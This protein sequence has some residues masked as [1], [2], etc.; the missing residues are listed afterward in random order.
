MLSRLNSLTAAGAN[1]VK[2]QLTQRSLAVASTS[3]VAHRSH[4]IVASKQNKNNSSNNN[5]NYNNSNNSRQSS[6]GSRAKYFAAAGV[7]AAGL[8]LLLSSDRNKAFAYSDAPSSNST[9]SKTESQKAQTSEEIIAEIKNRIEFVR[10]QLPGDFQALIDA[11]FAHILTP[12]GD[13]TKFAIFDYG[14]SVAS[15]I[16]HTLLSPTATG[17]QV[18]TLC[19]EALQN[20]FAAVCVNS[21]QA[22]RALHFLK[23]RQDPN[24][25]HQ[26]SVAAVVGFPLG[27]STTEVKFFEAFQMNKMGVHEL[28]MVINMGKLI[29]R[30]YL[31]VL[32][33]IAG[34]TNVVEKPICVKVILETGALNREQIIDGCILSVLAGATFVK[35]STGFGYGGATVE[36]VKLMKTVVGDNALVKASGGVKNYEDA[37]AMI[38]AGAARIGASKGISIVAGEQQQKK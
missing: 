23:A 31:E 10:K 28:D 27:A 2:K 7:T 4:T 34:V 35:T 21:S 5:S 20:K 6:S 17:A 8:G 9:P 29:D 13:P 33:D 26:V 12:T 14:A 25:P 37:M 30:Q 22:E 19:E 18:D 38:N 15:V 16:D 24:A 1:L 11:K 32:Y 36:A 3:T